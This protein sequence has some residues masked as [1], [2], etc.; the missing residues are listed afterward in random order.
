MRRCQRSEKKWGQTPFLID[1]E[2]SQGRIREWRAIHSPTM[3]TMV[4][5]EEVPMPRPRR[6]ELPGTAL[7]I[8]QRGNNRL[9]CFFDNRDRF[10]FLDVLRDAAEFEQVQ[11]HAWVLMSNHVHLLATPLVG[12]AASRM[13]QAIA[14]SYVRAFNLRRQR[15]GTLWEGRFRSTLVDDG[16]YVLACYRYIELNP[17]R[18][19][20]VERAADYRWSSYSA[21]AGCEDDRLTKP[22]REYLALGSEAELRRE[23]Y[24]EWVDATIEPSELEV[25]RMHTKR[26]CG[27]GGEAFRER[28]E[29]AAGRSVCSPSRGR[30]RKG[31]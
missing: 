21:N 5:A 15:T 26:Q 18:A 8:V 4:V 11:I 12:G 1:C 16:A 25:I 2:E 28:L 29:S 17:V 20:V 6:L 31:V 27:W 13:M 7:H 30:P 22:H 19:G 3:G 9:P 10:D 24:R 23:R 14:R